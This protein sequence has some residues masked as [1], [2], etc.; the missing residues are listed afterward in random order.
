MRKTYII[1]PPMP[2]PPSLLPFDHPS[3]QAARR[4]LERA[5]DQ[6]LAR[7]AELS[8][9]AAPTGAEGRRASR[10][11]ALFR[12]AGLRDVFVDE[13]GNVHGWVWESRPGGTGVVLAPPLGTPFTRD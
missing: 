3:I 2:L 8:A 1:S 5:D 9:I 7:Q 6:T 10:V 4:H 12:D 11:A 13:A